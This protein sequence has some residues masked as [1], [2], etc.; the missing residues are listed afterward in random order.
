MGAFEHISKMYRYGIRN[1]AIELGYSEANICVLDGNID[2]LKNRHGKVFE[3]LL[4]CSH[5]KDHRSIIEYARDLVSSWIFEDTMVQVLNLNGIETVLTGTDKN[6]EILGHVNV[7]SCSDCL[8]SFCGKSR[9]LEIVSD[10]TGWWELTG[11]MELRDSKFENLKRE[12][13]LL[14][15]VC[16]NTLK[17][18][19]LDFSKPMSAGYIQSH[20][21]YG[22]KPAW[23]IEI[24]KEELKKFSIP[25][26]VEHIKSVFS[27]F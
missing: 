14:L 11:R 15:G 23:S 2:V 20:K 5:N 7:S 12:K 3:N 4:S 21:P 17:Y 13:S 9:Y 16:T 18:V 24:K 8:I 27:D 1:K 19:L 26:L 6:R 22:G 25:H 10:Y